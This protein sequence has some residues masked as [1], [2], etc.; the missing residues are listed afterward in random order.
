MKSQGFSNNYACMC[1]EN[2][3]L[4]R[5]HVCTHVKDQIPALTAIREGLMRRGL[6]KHSSCINIC[7]TVKMMIVATGY[8]TTRRYGQSSCHK[9]RTFS[10]TSSTNCLQLS[11][12]CSILQLQFVFTEAI[13]WVQLQFLSKLRN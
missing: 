9:K 6:E 7:R 3:I 11:A 10:S 2:A 4:G 12:M 8:E 5:R 13:K 1:L